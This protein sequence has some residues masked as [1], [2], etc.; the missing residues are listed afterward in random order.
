MSCENWLEITEEANLKAKV[1][2][3]T[4]LNGKYE[5]ALTD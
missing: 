5:N 3:N 4:Q 2:R 1:V